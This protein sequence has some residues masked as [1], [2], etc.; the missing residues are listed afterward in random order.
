MAKAAQGK[1]EYRRNYFEKLSYQ[2][3]EQ[4]AFEWSVW[5]DFCLFQIRNLARKQNNGRKDQEYFLE[6]LDEVIEILSSCEESIYE[7]FILE[8]YDLLCF[9]YSNKIN[10]VINHKLSL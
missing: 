1:K 9:E 4:F 6:I 8:T 7:K 5:V 3:T 10:M 2:D